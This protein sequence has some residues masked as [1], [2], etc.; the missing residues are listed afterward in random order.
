MYRSGPD[1]NTIAA[2]SGDDYNFISL[3]DVDTLTRRFTE[4]FVEWGVL[5]VTD[6]LVDGQEENIRTIRDV[7]TR[8]VVSVSFSPDGQTIAV[9]RT[10]YPFRRNYYPYTYMWDVETLTG[11]RHRLETAGYPQRL[12]QS[13][14][15]NNH[16]SVWE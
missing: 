14:W 2:A 3:W 9:S 6:A 5:W 1:G 16:E 12:V 11:N 8:A 13:R 4:G 10:D 15:Q 7:H